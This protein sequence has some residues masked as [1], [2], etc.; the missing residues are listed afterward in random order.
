MPEKFAGENWNRRS[1]GCLIAFFVL[2]T[3]SMRRIA[4][5]KYSQNT[6]RSREAGTFL[7]FLTP[8]S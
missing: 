1:G 2:S 7:A 5:G 4:G 8:S 6:A 3:E